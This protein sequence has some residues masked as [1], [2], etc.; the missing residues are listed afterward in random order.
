MF[1]EVRGNQSIL[2]KRSRIYILAN[3][4]NYCNYLV[5]LLHCF[6]ITDLRDTISQP[7][8]FTFLFYTY[9]P[10]KPNLITYLLS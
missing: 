10:S 2:A 6:P 7:S 1:G 4:S 3:F 5:K 9:K 8:W